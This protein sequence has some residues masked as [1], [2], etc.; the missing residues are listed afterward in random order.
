[1]EG[2]P[3]VFTW[4]DGWTVATKDNGRCA[5]FEHT[6]L[7]H[8]EGAEVL[9]WCVCYKERSG[10]DDDD[11]VSS[12]PFPS[13]RPFRSSHPHSTCSLRSSGIAACCCDPG[14]SRRP[15]PCRSCL[16][17]STPSPLSSTP[18]RPCICP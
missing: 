14:A 4:K 13:S 8:D 1:M 12:F 16:Q 9:T 11:G 5:Q 2:S 10:D 7:I 3:E 15:P 18:S 17:T 6:I